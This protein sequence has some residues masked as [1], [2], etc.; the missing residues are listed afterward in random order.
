MKLY[1]AGSIGG[2]VDV[3]ENFKM[4]DRM[5]ELLEDRGYEVHVPHQAFIDNKDYSEGFIEEYEANTNPKEIAATDIGHLV[6]CDAVV[7]FLDQPSHGV[8]YEI[9]F[10]HSCDK[11]I[12]GLAKDVGGVSRIIT[13]VLELFSDGRLLEYSEIEE[14]VETVDQVI[15]EGMKDE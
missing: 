1:L 11:P 3:V 4:F 7:A 12:I 13:G 2:A 10:S 8:G 9:G 6:L 15:Q 14:A 5:A